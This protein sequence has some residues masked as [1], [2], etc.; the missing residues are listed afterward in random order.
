M[1]YD[2]KQRLEQIK[3]MALEELDFSVR[4][5]NSL[6]RVNI[7]SVG[8]L[9][10][11]TEKEIASIR[12]FSRHQYDE[13][14]DKLQLYGLYLKDAAYSIPFRKVVGNLCIVLDA[15]SL[16]SYTQSDIKDSE[17]IEG[18]NSLLCYV[19]IDNMMGV[20]YEV[21][22]ATYFYFGDYYLVGERAQLS[23]KIRAE[24]LAYNRVYPIDN[25]ALMKKYHQQIMFIDEHYTCNDEMKELRSLE[26]LDNFRHPA[27][28]DDV[29]VTLYS[30]KYE[31][32]EG[33]WVSLRKQLNSMFNG[34]QIFMG[35]L[36]SEPWKDYGVH[37]GQ[38]I[39]FLNHKVDDHSLL[40]YSPGFNEMLSEGEKND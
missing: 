1:D 17:K 34:E 19:Y 18:A 23:M 31:K 10:E 33:V 30:D 14:I 6:K 15:A 28:P 12:N 2:K 7:H 24:S 22:A 4:T 25:R 21:L 29:I 16:S 5:Y 20:T 35:K 39:Y 13:V 9:I 27:I 37:S 26:C 8:D 38:D 32:C 11:K 3:R 36:L 40:L